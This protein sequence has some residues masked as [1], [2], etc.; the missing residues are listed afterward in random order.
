MKLHKNIIVAA[1]A[2]ITVLAPVISQTSAVLADVAATN[3]TNINTNTN[4]NNPDTSATDKT[5]TPVAEPISQPIQDNDPEPQTNIHKTKKT[6]S[7]RH[8][9]AN[10][11][12]NK[13]VKK[14]Q[15]LTNKTKKLALYKKTLKHFRNYKTKYAKT[16][17]NYLN[18][19]IKWLKRQIK[20]DVPTT[21]PSGDLK[22]QPVNPPKKEPKHHEGWG[23]TILYD[24]YLNDY[25][26]YKKNPKVNTPLM[27]QDIKALKKRGYKFNADMSDKG[28]E[29]HNKKL[30]KRDDKLIDEGKLK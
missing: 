22:P 8:Q 2:G 11:Y 20:K 28:Y 29:A 30:A 15:K 16:F 13:N 14:G 3:Q 7:K 23:N 27:K 1:V 6:W 10:N 12:F 5:E 18:A 24:N 26:Y 17:K 25:K 9:K 4:T 19:E 21:K